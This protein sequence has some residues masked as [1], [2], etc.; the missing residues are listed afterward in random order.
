MPVSS[1]VLEL[2]ASVAG[3]KPA[4]TGDTTADTTEHIDNVH[5]E[6]LED[7]PLVTNTLV[8]PRHQQDQRPRIL[9]LV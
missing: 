4:T 6:E 3:V 8:Q 9:C 2:D 5:E 7:A 1:P